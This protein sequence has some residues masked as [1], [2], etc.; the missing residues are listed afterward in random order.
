MAASVVKSQYYLA[1]M[2]LYLPICH[3]ADTSQVGPTAWSQKSKKSNDLEFKTKSGFF[4]NTYGPLYLHLLF[5]METLGN[6]N[7]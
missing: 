7:F 4:A 5:I 6:F 1:N 3:Q 2:M